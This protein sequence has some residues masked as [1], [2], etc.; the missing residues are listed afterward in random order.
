MP[1]PAARVDRTKSPTVVEIRASVARLSPI[2]LRRLREGL[3]RLELQ[4]I[5]DMIVSG[6]DIPKVTAIAHCARAIEAVD[7]LQGGLR[8]R[9]QRPQPKE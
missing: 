1:P 6:I 3:F 7:Q 4:L 8:E 5:E 9:P 2:S